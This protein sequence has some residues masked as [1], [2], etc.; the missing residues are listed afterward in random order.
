MADMILDQLG[1]LDALLGRARRDV[2]L[3]MGVTYGEGARATL[4]AA[5]AAEDR[6]RVRLEAHRLRGAVAPFG[7]QSLVALLQQLETTGAVGAAE[8]DAALAEF[9]DACRAALAS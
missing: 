3:G 7:V 2:L 5:L 1:Q 8:I 6:T 4:A 9:V